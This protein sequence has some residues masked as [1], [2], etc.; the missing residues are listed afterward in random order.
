MLTVPPHDRRE[1]PW[2]Q[3]IRAGSAEDR[4]IRSVI[5]A[6]PPDLAAF[7]VRVP[8]HLIADSEESVR[9]VASLDETKGEHL[10]PLATLLLRAE[11]VAS[12]KIEHQEAS[13]EDFARALHGIK[14]N[15]SAIS[16]VANTGALDLLLRGPIDADGIL[17]AHGRLMADDPRE[18]PYAGRWREMQNWIGGSDYSPRGALYVPPPANLVDEKMTDLIRFSNRVDLPALP[19]AAI[20]HAQ[21]ESIHPFTDGNGRIGRAL[22]AAILRERGTT[23]QI[24]VPIAS[25]LVAERERY[26]DT[27][28]AYRQGDGEP[29]VAA[30]ARSALIA[31]EEGH[32]TADRLAA[33]PAQWRER[34]GGPRGGSAAALVLDTLAI[35]PIFT[36][37]ELRRRLEI[38]AASL[39]RAIERL[40]ETEVIRPLT[41]RKRD[42][43][44][45]AGDLL[46][47]LDDLGLRIGIRARQR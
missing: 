47:E 31:A 7:D 8:G 42:Q 2:R 45:G 39:Y 28:D 34:A 3:S 32:T 25:A 30:F 29:I 24:V 23:R 35:V 14:A 26:F 36:A 46:D 22:A 16:M 10:R 12:S 17:G 6:I 41:D 4:K 40:E 19:Q 9:A 11:S 21:F 13:V 44:W 27:L 1:V 33:M 38:P 18:A 43:V 37:D 15:S 5:A 20:A